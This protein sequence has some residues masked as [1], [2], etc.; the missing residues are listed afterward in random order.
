MFVPIHTAHTAAATG[1]ATVCDLEATRGYNTTIQVFS[2]SY[3]RVQGT[4]DP[5]RRFFLSFCVAVGGG[6]GGSWWDSGER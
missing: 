2:D 4:N 5:S 3:T 1:A 6:R